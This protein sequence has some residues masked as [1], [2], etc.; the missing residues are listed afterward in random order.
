MSND[1]KPYEKW[2]KDQLKDVDVPD[3][4]KAW[5][6]ISN[7]LQPGITHVPTPPSTPWFKKWWF[8]ANIVIVVITATLFTKDIFYPDSQ[9]S[10]SNNTTNSSTIN[11]RTNQKNIALPKTKD[12]SKTVYIKGSSSL[13]ENTILPTNLKTEITA[14]D[15]SSTPTTNPKNRLVTINNKVKERNIVQNKK[16]QNTFLQ[17]KSIKNNDIR[18]NNDKN[19]PK[20][21]S[22]SLAS[23]NNIPK[24]ST[25]KFR[26]KKQLKFIINGTENNDP[27]SSIN[28][29]MRIF[30]S[31]SIDNNTILN[32][33]NKALAKGTN[34]E[35]QLKSIQYSV[36]TTIPTAATLPNT[37]TINNLQ[38]SN[39]LQ[40]NQLASSKTKKWSARVGFTV[41]QFIPFNTQKEYYQL[42]GRK[43]LFDNLPS[44]HVNIKYRFNYKWSL[45]FSPQLYVPQIAYN[46]ILDRTVETIPFDSGATKTTVTRLG[47]MHY[48]HF[49]LSIRY[50][51]NKKFEIEA[52]MDLAILHNAKGYNESLG[53]SPS[54]TSRNNYY[55]IKIGPLNTRRA[56]NSLRPFDIKGFIGMTYN[57]NNNLH[58]GLLFTQAF[59]SYLSNPVSF[60]PLF[61]NQSA[62]ST[63]NNFSFQLFFKYDLDLLK[64]KK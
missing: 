33:S 53:Y 15:K 5:K 55:D 32:A 47:K 23:N 58:C 37:S 49:P 60:T 22:T 9:K 6:Q 59:T 64:K 36:N 17:N 51:I 2:M 63:T 62:P 52:G 16:N 43:W 20:T 11:V 3:M 39:I 46:N 40:S 4:D 54:P 10:K 1:L 50:N 44:L 56:Y 41:N 42:V 18:L 26:N 24:S 35:K 25:K 34:A 29:N 12:I 48:S 8:S 7:L 30:E 27:T 14:G 38:Q 45:S 31:K 28:Q 13:K 21:K 57:L 61:S 19:V